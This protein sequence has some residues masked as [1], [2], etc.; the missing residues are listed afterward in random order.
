MSS[1]ERNGTSGEPPKEGSAAAPVVALDASG[2]EAMPRAAI[3]GAVM[4]AG[5]DLKV[6]LVGNEERLS[7]ELRGRGGSAI[8][9]VHASDT[10]GMDE[11]AADVRRRREASVMVAMRLVKEGRANACVSMGHSGA[12]MAAALLT[13]GRLPGV[14]RPAILANVPRDN[15]FAALLDAGANADSRAPWL[16]EFAL[17]GS[18][19]VESV[20][21]VTSP[22]V[23]LMSIGEE[24]NKGNELTREAHAL[25]A[26]TPSIRFI[27]NVE[28]GDLFGGQV[29]VVVT[30]GF[31]GNVILK[32]AEGEAK[33]LFG[34]IRTAL[35]GGWRERLGGL[36]ARPAL[37]RVAA[38]M[39]P[40]EY[41]AQ[42]L[43][44]VNG[45]AFI[46]HGSADERAVAS[47]LTTARRAVRA[48]ALERL[49]RALAAAPPP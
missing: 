8:E 20:W 11:H 36:L 26:N 7:A 2:G 46:G 21:G 35:T 39:D 42:P 48:G 27:G 13:L 9:I 19:Y 24:P 4:A 6:L 38:R 18:A 29:D 3:E 17:M 30:D 32:L 45:Y 15:G 33:A 16:R 44:G 37:R 25:L 41:G 40:A 34:W 5:S 1:G 10:I 31:T 14:S 12:T 28:G 22:R 47:A 43:L 23:G 49:L